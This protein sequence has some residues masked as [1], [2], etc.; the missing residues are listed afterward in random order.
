M[1]VPGM[2]GHRRRLHNLQRNRRGTVTADTYTAKHK[3]EDTI[4]LLIV[5]AGFYLLWCVVGA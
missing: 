2:P 1:V 4:G 5:L 3:A